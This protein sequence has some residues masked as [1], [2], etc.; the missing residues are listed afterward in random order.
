MRWMRKSRT[1]LI[2]S[3]D[4]VTLILKM[5]EFMD[6]PE[7]WELAH[8]HSCSAE[9]ITSGSVRLLLCPATAAPVLWQLFF[10]TCF[11]FFSSEMMRVSTEGVW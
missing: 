7:S 11:C 5:N 8:S 4:N 2:F 10:C 3:S 6:G 9:S 1:V